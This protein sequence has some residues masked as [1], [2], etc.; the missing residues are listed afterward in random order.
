M[1]P[2]ERVPR[3]FKEVSASEQ[4]RL[5]YSIGEERYVAQ[6]PN[7]PQDKSDAGQRPKSYGR[8]FFAI[9]RKVKSTAPQTVKSFYTTVL[10][11]EPEMVL[12]I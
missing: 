6:L 8:P 12:L 3:R 10:V 7:Y 5:N 4:A 1:L 9:S 2:A 11:G